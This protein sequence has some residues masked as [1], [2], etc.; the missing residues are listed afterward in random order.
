MAKKKGKKKGVPEGTPL[1]DYLTQ[2]MQLKDLK[3]Y[4]VKLG[5]ALKET[6]SDKS[7]FE[8]D[9]DKM[10]RNLINVACRLYLTKR[11]VRRL[12]REIINKKNLCEMKVLQKRNEL[13]EI[14]FKQTPNF[15]RSKNDVFVAGYEAVN[16]LF[17]K[18]DQMFKDCVGLNSDYY[19]KYLELEI[20]F[21]ANKHSSFC[22]KIDK[23]NENNLN[24][25]LRKEKCYYR[26]IDESAKA[27][28]R[29]KA[30]ILNDIVQKKESL[31]E[32]VQKEHF[33]ETVDIL[34]S[35][36][37]IIKSNFTII[38]ELREDL[39]DIKLMHRKVTREFKELKEKYEL[40]CSLIKQAQKEL[41]IIRPVVYYLHHTKAA[42]LTFSK[43]LELTEEETT[44]ALLEIDMLEEFI[45]KDDECNIKLKQIV[46]NDLLSF[47][48]MQVKTHLF[49]M[50]LGNKIEEM[51][52]DRVRIGKL[53]LFPMEPD[54]KPFQNIYER[55]E[56]Y[57]KS[58]VDIVERVLQANFSH[59]SSLG[60]HSSSAPT[61]PFLRSSGALVQKNTP[62]APGK[63]SVF[64]A[65]LR[66]QNPP[67]MLELVTSLPRV[68]MRKTTEHMAPLMQIFEASVYIGSVRMG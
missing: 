57:R 47:R 42:A 33:L 19:K 14:R 29:N 56:C 53:A 27:E 41:V 4:A 59:L 60:L 43:K 44:N 25:L 20:A 45:R 15:Y 6:R 61:L 23:V 26:V 13:A 65:K 39:L 52:A 21:M 12:D 24:K 9:R 22:D 11:D 64:N 32:N 62:M 51:Y 7:N 40:H 68:P 5:Q 31:I 28:V 30:E 10:L 48:Q 36:E 35:F 54:L 16:L 67:R 55:Y 1:E 37:E 17:H 46:I 18:E 66:K 2:E 50:N 63:R 3:K 49:M 38:N 34:R 8:I 58:V